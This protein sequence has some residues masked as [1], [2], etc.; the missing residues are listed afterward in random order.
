[1]RLA[2]DGGSARRSFAVALLLGAIVNVPGSAVADENGVSF[3]LPGS[4]GSLA[5][6]PKV[7]GWSFA[8]VY[9]HTS[10]SAG[11]SI[12]RSREVTIGNLSRTATVNANVNLHSGHQPPTPPEAA[13]WSDSRRR[14]SVT[15]HNPHASHSSWIVPFARKPHDAIYWT[16]EQNIGEDC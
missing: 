12:A 5:A 2:I 8:S 13:I 1:M 9:Y 3:W 7:P 15:A 4:Y 10:V 11:S 6:T 16:A 14:C